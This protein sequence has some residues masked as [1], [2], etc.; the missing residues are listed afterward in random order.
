MFKKTLLTLGILLLISL[1]SLPPLAAQEG[2]TMTFAITSFDT[3]DIH[4]SGD[5]NAMSRRLVA[6]RYPGGP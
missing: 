4:M 1:L 6:R 2:E 3:L 5:G